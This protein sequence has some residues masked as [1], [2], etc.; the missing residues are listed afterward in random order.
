VLGRLPG[1]PQL[2]TVNWS[3][4]NLWRSSDRYAVVVPDR[5]GESREVVGFEVV[6][7]APVS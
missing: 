1:L 7:V 3:T 4:P 2:W 6:G 5:G